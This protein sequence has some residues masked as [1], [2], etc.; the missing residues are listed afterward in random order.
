MN[1]NPFLRA[2]ALQPLPSFI[3]L[4]QTS[5]QA[6]SVR[7]DL[8]DADTLTAHPF[9]TR[10]KLKTLKHPTVS[11][12]GFLDVRQSPQEIMNGLETPLS[13]NLYLKAQYV[14]SGKEISINSNNIDV[15]ILR[16]A[17]KDNSTAKIYMTGEIKFMEATTNPIKDPRN[18]LEQAEIV[19]FTKA[20]RGPSL[21][22]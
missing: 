8:I 18:Q 1:A 19:S 20:N 15:I 6:T 4:T 3:E 5:G 12:D 10:L 9:G 22:P 16:D 7:T 21:T 13:V 17:A 11:I 2:S 14:V